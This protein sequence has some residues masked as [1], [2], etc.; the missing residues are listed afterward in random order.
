MRRHVEKPEKRNCLSPSSSLSITASL[1]P[2]SQLNCNDP[3][4]SKAVRAGALLVQKAACGS[5]WSMVN[6]NKNNSGEE[7]TQSDTIETSW[8]EHFKSSDL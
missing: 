8:G 7:T 2:L 1:P 6:N 3:Y 5:R 4:W